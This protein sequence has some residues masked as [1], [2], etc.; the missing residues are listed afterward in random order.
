MDKLIDIIIPAYNS[1][2]TIVRLLGSILCQTIIDNIIVTIVNDCGDNYSEI[3]KLFSNYMSVREISLPENRGPGVARQLG[4][5]S[6]NCPFIVFADSDDSFDGA[7]ALETLLQEINKYPN[8]IGVFA[9][10]FLEVRDKELKFAQFPPNFVWAFAKIYRR[11]KLEIYQVRFNNSRANEDVGFN[12]YINLVV[13]NE[14]ER[15][16]MFNATVY[17]WHDNKNSITRINPDFVFSD[18]VCGYIDNMIYAINRAKKYVKG[19]IARQALNK[20]IITTMGDL[21]LFYWE[22]DS[23]KPEFS[24]KNFK[25]V[26]R[27]YKE[28]FQDIEIMFDSSFINGLIIETFKVK[29]ET[30]SSILP[31]ETYFQFMERIK[32]EV[33][34]E[35]E[36]EDK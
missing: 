7:F 2:K 23:K 32:E 28:L 10:H 11:E 34:K 33:R 36:N 27:Y 21:Y 35:E 24:E 19:G 26:V 1:H 22:A 8:T 3:V 6:T 12:R 18:N 4:I 14:E 9:E 29:K 30:L 17:N 13:E 20:E 15:P 5:D 31:K 16:V 25:E